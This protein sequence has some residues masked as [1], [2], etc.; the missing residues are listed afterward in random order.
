VKRLIG[1]PGDTVA[2]RNGFISVNGKTLAEP[3]VE[4]A[5]RDH[6]SDLVGPVLLTYRPPGRIALH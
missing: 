1:P 6:E 3:Y 4:P 2:E 5:F